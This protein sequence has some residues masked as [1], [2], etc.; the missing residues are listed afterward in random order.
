MRL[1]MIEDSGLA[2]YSYIVGADRGDV[3]VVDP[4]RDVDVYLD[5]AQRHTAHIKYA[6]RTSWRPTSTP[7]VPPGPGT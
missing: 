1:E 4:R 7:T 2:H 5:W 3:A 6:S